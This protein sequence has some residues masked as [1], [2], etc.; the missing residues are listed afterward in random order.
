ML[1]EIFAVLRI[2][3][4]TLVGNARLAIR[5]LDT[6]QLIATR[7]EGTSRKVREER[8]DCR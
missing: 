3:I 5:S 6:N 8:A 1:F 2:P 4:R 7:E